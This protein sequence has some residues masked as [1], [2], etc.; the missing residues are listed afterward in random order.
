MKLVRFWWRWWGFGAREE[1]GRRDTAL[2]RAP[3]E[4]RADTLASQEGR[5]GVWPGF[6]LVTFR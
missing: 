5:A 1:A 4:A 3:E 2:G 6:R